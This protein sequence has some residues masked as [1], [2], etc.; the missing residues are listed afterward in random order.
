MSEKLVTVTGGSGFV[1]QL[2]ARGLRRHGYRIQNF[3][4][5][6]GRLVSLLRRRYLGTASSRLGLGAAALIHRSQR[7]LEPAL[8]RTGLI[9]PTWDDILDL[10]SRLA[11]RFAGSHAVIHLAGIA[12]PFAEGA[13]DEDFQRI[14]YHGAINSFEAARD[15]GVAKFVFASSAQVYGINQPVS[16]EQLPILESN[17]CPTP[18]EG[19]NMYGHLKVEFERYLANACPNGGTQGISLRLEQP[20]VRS[21]EPWNFYISTSIENLVAG[22]ACAL[23][24]PDS[25]ASNVFNIADAEVDPSIVDVQEFIR[26]HWPHV[27]N[28]TTEN[29]CLLSTEKARRQLSYQPESGGTYYDHSVVW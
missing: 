20:G 13:A 15:A 3:D 5:M 28:H 26:A 12:H 9:K 11:A 18:G 16:I 14:N 19:Q 10:R 4:R 29:E 22:F 6:Q 25:F 2:L 27:P 17:Y 23:D 24:A 1:G 21:T 8:I 7:R